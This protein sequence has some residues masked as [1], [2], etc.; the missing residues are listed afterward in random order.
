MQ[1][2]IIIADDHLLFAD[3]L[4]TILKQSGN[5]EITAIVSNGDDLLKALTTHEVDLILLDVSMPGTNGLKAS[6][7]IVKLYPAIRILMVTMND[8]ADTIKALIQNGIHGII[9]KNTGKIELLL[10]ISELLNGN[11]YFSQKITQQLAAGYKALKHETWQLTKREKEVLYL[12]YEGLSTAEIAQ[13]L[14][15]SPYTVET[16]RKNLF[17]KSGLNKSSQLIKQALELGYIKKDAL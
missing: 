9:L 3:G 5:F 1:T 11:S 4:S 16:H 10:A 6:E 8:S 12:I 15:I 13:K 14:F 17:V 7:I 2:R